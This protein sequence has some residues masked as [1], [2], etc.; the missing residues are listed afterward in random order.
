MQTFDELTDSGSQKNG[1]RYQCL[2][3]GNRQI[4]H[5]I[6]KCLNLATSCK[7]IF[8]LVIAQLFTNVRLGCLFSGKFYAPG[9]II[10]EGSYSL[11][12]REEA[13]IIR[14]E[15]YYYTPSMTWM[16][17]VQNSDAF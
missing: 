4:Y 11:I 5:P 6:G 9:G 2:L 14:I 17:G 10:K 3:E 8:L 15:P 1:F 13:G 16:S 7:T 12:C